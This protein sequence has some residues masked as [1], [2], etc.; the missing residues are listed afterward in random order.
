M[1]KKEIDMKV[2][3]QEKI[4]L[5]HVDNR[6]TERGLASKESQ[7]ERKLESKAIYDQAADR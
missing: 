7:T 2:T 5:E 6:H 1:T 3:A 4:T